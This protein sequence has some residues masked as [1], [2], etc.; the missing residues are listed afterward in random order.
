MNHRARAGFVLVV[1]A[2]TIAQISCDSRLAPDDPGVNSCTVVT[3]Y[4]LGAATDGQLSTNDC[5][6]VDA[7][8][9]DFYTV[10]LSGG[11]YY[12]DMTA[13]YST[14]LVL[15]GADRTAIGVHDDVGHGANT[16]LKALL[17]A[18]TYELDANAYPGS[19][20]AYTL[21]SGSIT[22]G[23]TNCEIVFVAKGT[24]T[25]QNLETTDCDASTS[26]SD[27][28]IIYIGAGQ[29]IVVT[30]SSSAFDSYL[31][32]YGAGGR[33]AFNDNGGT[34]SNDATLSYTSTSPVGDF[35]VLRAEATGF[36]TGAYAL[37]I[38]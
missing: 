12:F 36:A 28:Y 7:S 30:L 26:Y 15:R 6:L 4:S 1:L 32:L 5:T 18:G 2:L 16:M 33:V 21:T 17:P 10:T 13:G 24:S 8:Y 34:T 31:E 25:T 3:P 27:D 14:Y 23:V 9:V 20:G 11:W 22:T 35:F 19:V 29:S 38:Q 37:S